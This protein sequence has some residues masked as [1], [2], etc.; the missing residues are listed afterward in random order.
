MLYSKFGGTNLNYMSIQ[1]IAQTE[2]RENYDFVQAWSI[3]IFCASF[4]HFCSCQIENH[5]KQGNNIV[6]TCF[7][8]LHVNRQKNMS[9]P[10]S[11]LV[12]CVAFKAKSCRHTHKKTSLE[13]LRSYLLHRQE[14][15][16]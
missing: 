15:K 13:R 8:N 4:K 2:Y 6:I 7:L 11:H 14:R 16:H 12:I 5:K 1:N 3:L 9:N 10:H